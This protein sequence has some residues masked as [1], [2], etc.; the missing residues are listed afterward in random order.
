VLERLTNL[1]GISGVEAPVRDTILAEIKDYID[2]YK[3]DA[4]GNLL[5]WKGNKNDVK[6]MFAAHMDEVGFMITHI[7]KTGEMRFQPVGGIDPRVVLAKRVFIGKNKIPAVI[8]VK[9]VHLLTDTE[10]KNIPK[11]KE[12]FMD[13]GFTS[14]KEV[15]KAGIKR[16]DFAVFPTEYRET[17]K[18]IFAKAI[19]DRIGCSIMVELVKKTYPYPVAF[20]FTVQEEVGLRGASVVGYS[21]H[22]EYALILEGT[23]AGDFPQKK[24]IGRF[25]QMGKGPVI[26]IMD[27]SCICNREITNLIIKTAEENN[28]PYQIKKPGIGGTDAGVI[29][30]SREGVKCGVVAL[31][32]RYIH[33]PVSVVKRDD[34]DNMVKLVNIFVERIKEIL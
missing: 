16:G 28:I 29:T 8:G 12:L 34:I 21:V 4:M 17:N 5:A 2:E 20:A 19:D 33:S 3:I 15:E 23:G 10:E 32:A 22:P 9:A 18:T 14:D 6:L 30:K 13:A 31:P 11:F 27:S 26:T 1:P 25:P 7:E 24:D